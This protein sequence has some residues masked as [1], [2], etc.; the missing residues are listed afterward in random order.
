MDKSMNITDMSYG[1]A[2]RYNVILLF[3]SLHQ[4]IMFSLLE[5]NQRE[6]VLFIAL[7]VLVMYMT[8][9]LFKYSNDNDIR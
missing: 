4:S 3:L 9:I 5:V 1:I 2:S 6:I 8:I 7:Y